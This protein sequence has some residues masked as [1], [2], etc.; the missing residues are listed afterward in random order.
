M[1]VSF[2]VVDLVKGK[3]VVATEFV[4]IPSGVDE[5]HRKATE[6]D[7]AKYAA[8]Y[9]A[10]KAGV[11]AAPVVVPGKPQA[12]FGLYTPTEGP[13]SKRVP[14]EYVMVYFDAHASH[15][16]ATDAD[17]ARFKGEYAEFLAAKSPA[18]AVVPVAAPVVE[19]PAPEPEEPPTVEDAKPS[20]RRK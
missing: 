19:E 10:F 18:L 4:R 15:R 6:A 2:D 17:R 5:V 20:K 12:E 8:E 14:T 3:D 11:V 16:P 9:A 7:R 1:S 13:K